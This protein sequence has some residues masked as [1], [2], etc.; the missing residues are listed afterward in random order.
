MRHVEQIVGRARRLVARVSQSIAES[1]PRR[2]DSAFRLEGLQRHRRGMQAVC[3]C[4]VALLVV[5]A[6]DSYVADP[7]RF[8]V[9]LWIRAAGAAVCI[10]I[11]ALLS[12]RNGAV[13]S[14]WLA[15]AFVVTI[16]LV[17]HALAI[18]TGGQA[19][20][21]YDRLN[22]LILALA[23]FATWSASW[24]ALA[25][26]LIIG[27]YLVG[28][29]AADGL[30]ANH[31]VVQNLGR[32]IAA[33]VVTIGA[34]TIRERRRWQAFLAHRQLGET[35][36]QRLESEQRYRLLVETAGSAIVVL[37]SD[38]RIVDF[39]REA[40]MLYG[41]SR[42]EVMGK[43][44]LALF[45][46][47]RLV[48]AF[49]GLIEGVLAG[50]PVRAIESPVRSRTGEVRMVIW[51]VTRVDA[52]N[53]SAVGVICVGQDITERKRAADEV[54]RLNRELEQRAVQTRTS[55][56]RASEA[57][58]PHLR[59]SADRHHHHRCRWPCARRQSGSAIDARLQP[60]RAAGDDPARS[61]RRAR[62]HAQPQCLHAVVPAPW[63][64]PVDRQALRES[65]RR[66]GLGARGVGGRTRR[67]RPVR[68]RPD[69]GR[70][71]D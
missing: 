56:L 23:V 38:Y 54:E 10:V 21:Q 43:N 33:A 31:F 9:L 49:Q 24:A 57:R 3:F 17:L 66:R 37:A 47:A 29:A 71:R 13:W 65:Q 63:H 12:R 69:D 39:N 4:A 58:F 55:E 6:I 64:R 25:C 35:H 62:P 42:D 2:H 1:R 14:R 48:G 28:T 7:D 60:R 50:N 70:G 51:N 53:G 67:A 22:L 27:V 20:P 46:P 61:H 44:Y 5:S 40:E 30:N 36:V 41:C 34:T 16:A 32:M 15:L 52:G 26:A 18:E 45:L 59:L 19:S 8:Y 11:L 68:L